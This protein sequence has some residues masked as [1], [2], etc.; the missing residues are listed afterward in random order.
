MPASLPSDKTLC[1]RKEAFK[2]RVKLLFF[3]YGEQEEKIVTTLAKQFEE[4]KEK[5]LSDEEFLRRREQLKSSTI[6]AQENSSSHFKFP[7]EAT[8][9]REKS[10]LF[11][12]QRRISSRVSTEIS[13]MRVSKSYTSPVYNR[14]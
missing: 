1:L 3:G 7:T 9:T 4:F 10:Q 6:F 13:F 2:E 14:L 11:S 12:M 5:G 8:A